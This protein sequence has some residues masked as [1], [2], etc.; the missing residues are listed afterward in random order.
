MK[1]VLADAYKKA[2]IIRGHA[3][4]KSTKTYASAHNRDPNFY[5]FTRSLEAY[6]QSI[7]E[8]TRLVI[9]P[10]SEFFRY[11]GKSKR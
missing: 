10:E 9:S 3:D 8:G 4:A 1:F 2:Q 7:A 5:A 6:K 11:F